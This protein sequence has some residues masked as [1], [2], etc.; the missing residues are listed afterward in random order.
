MKKLLLIVAMGLTLFAHP[1]MFVKIK[2][3][4][5][6]QNKKI[7]QIDVVWEFDDLN[8]AMLIMDYD[9]DGNQKFDKKESAKFKKI[10]FDTLKQYS[11][12]THLKIDKK[13]IDIKNLIS[14]FRLDLKNSLFI[15]KYSLNLEKFTPKKLFELGF[16]D[17][18]FYTSMELEKKYIKIDKSIKYKIKADQTDIYLGYIMEVKK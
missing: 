10:V 11:Y 3:D 4:V 5:K 2:L 6:S 16:W 9:L 13:K 18:E 8:S 7:N 14:N 12:Y 1:H 17:E 15:V